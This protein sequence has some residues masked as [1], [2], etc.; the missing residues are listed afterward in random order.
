MRNAGALLCG[1]LSLLVLLCTSCSEGNRVIVRGSAQ[2]YSSKAFV[3]SASFRDT[4]HYWKGYRFRTPA[5]EVVTLVD[6]AVVTES[7]P[8]QGADSVWLCLASVRD[9]EVDM[10][11]MSERSL[12]QNHR[13]DNLLAVALGLVQAAG[14]LG[15]LADVPG[16]CYS[17]EWMEFYFHPTLNPWVWP[18]PLALFILMIWL[19]P[20]VVIGLLLRYVVSPVRYR[21]GHCH[22]PLQHLGRCPHCGANNT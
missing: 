2:L 21:C 3:D 14:F 19:L 1:I 10:Q 16:G 12:L 17:N 4:H 9:G 18:W 13:P 8:E 5:D 15:P 6:V 20:I 7:Q 11:W 22:G